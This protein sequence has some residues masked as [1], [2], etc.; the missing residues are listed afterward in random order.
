[1]CSTPTPTPQST[2][3]SRKMLRFSLLPV[4][5]PF[6]LVGFCSGMVTSGAGRGGSMYSADLI[7]PKFPRKKSW[8]RK[9]TP[10]TGFGHNRNRARGGPQLKGG[11]F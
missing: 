4:L 7:P 3:D 2:S 6:P 5:G 1:M 8:A 9:A 11:V 10:Q